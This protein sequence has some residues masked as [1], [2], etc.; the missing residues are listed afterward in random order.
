M[1]LARIQAGGI[2]VSNEPALVRTVL[3][4]CVAACLFD[5]VARV[6]GM[7]L[8]GNVSTKHSD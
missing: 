7:N 5:P 1:K 3:G 2:Y 8:N 4:S 6:G